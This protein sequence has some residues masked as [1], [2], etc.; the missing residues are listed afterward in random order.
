V[1]IRQNDGN[2]VDVDPIQEFKKCK[3]DPIYF[4]DHY[5]FVVDP[6]KGELPFKL[7]D[8]QRRALKEYQ[9]HQF[10]IIKKPRQM[11]L[12]WLTACYGLWLINFHNDKFVLV[13]SIRDQEA[14]EFRDKAKYSYDR[15]PDILRVDKVD[16]SKHSLNLENGSQFL[17]IPQTKEAGRSKSL[18]LLILDE[19]AFQQ[20]ADDIWAAAWPTLSTGGRAILI[21]TTNGIGNLYHKVYTEAVNG[22]NDFNVIEISWDEYPGR[23]EKWL[24]QQRRQLGSEK[25]FR[26]EILGEFVGSGDTVLRA[27]TLDRLLQHVKEPLRREEIASKIATELLK[28]S[29]RGEFLL[30]PKNLWIWE[31]PKPG[32]SYILAADVGTGSGQD[33]SAFHVINVRTNEQVAEFQNN[34]VSSADYAAIIK[35]VARMYNNALVVIE[36]NSWGLATFEKVYK[37]PQDPYLNVY[38]TKNG[39]ASWE[40]TGKNRPL[41]IDSLITA[42]ENEEVIINSKRLVN[43]LQT[44]VWHGAKAEAL[45][46]YHDDLVLSLA[47]ALYVRK[48]ATVFQPLGITT[49]ID[50]KAFKYDKKDIENYQECKQ[51]AIGDEDN[52]DESGYMTEKAIYQ[53]LTK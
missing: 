28:D 35:I 43:E 40:T 51:I 34:F 10:N 44:F 19:V 32:E 12:S 46:G 29:R 47:I 1:K 27:E 31:L 20:Y 6:I 41:I 26:A 4:I 48:G 13:I 3:L 17:S 49:S 5:C 7:F 42:I 22:Q 39:K 16:K 11:G 53:W 36:S 50:K 38:V 30:N 45:R 14:M 9:E 23:D 37:D 25:R 2:I 15:L 33:S 52:Y 8:Y 18:S 24:I 21:S